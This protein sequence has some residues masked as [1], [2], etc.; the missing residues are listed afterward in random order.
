MIT[1]SLRLQT[2]N[3]IVT[4]NYQ[5]WR[6]RANMLKLKPI[7]NKPFCID[8]STRELLDEIESLRLKLG[9]VIDRKGTQNDPEVLSVSRELDEAV[10][11]YYR[12]F[13]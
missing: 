9:A 1:L 12:L 7:N 10:N 3:S 6:V 8:Y 5:V 2:K 4:N 11:K 13:R